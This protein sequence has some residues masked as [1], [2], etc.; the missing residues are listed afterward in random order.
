MIQETSSTPGQRAALSNTICGDPSAARELERMG[1]IRNVRVE[2][3]LGGP[4]AFFDLT[5][6]GDTFVQRH[7]VVPDSTASS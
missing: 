2:E 5:D 4:V 6:A 7:Y 1:L 3:R